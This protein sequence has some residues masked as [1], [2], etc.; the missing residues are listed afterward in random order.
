MVWTDKGIADSLGRWKAR[1]ISDDELG[2]LTKVLKA[3]GIR[4]L[5]EP[6]ECELKGCV[7]TRGKYPASAGL[8]AWVNQI[9]AGQRDPLEFDTAHL[10]EIVQQWRTDQD[11]TVSAIV[12][13]SG[14]DAPFRFDELQEGSVIRIQRYGCV[15]HPF[16][17]WGVG[18]HS[19][20]SASRPLD[21]GSS[22]EVYPQEWEVIHGG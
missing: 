17:R 5:D 1:E 13:G 4:R 14:G 7:L 22:V 15:W 16:H 19:L 10:Y 18:V 11:F 9:Q 20:L 3:L 8:R 6:L 21:I 2:F 12:W